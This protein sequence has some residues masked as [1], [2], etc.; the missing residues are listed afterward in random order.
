MLSIKDV[1]AFG[2]D[3]R[4]Y[5]LLTFEDSFSRFSGEQDV[6]TTGVIGTVSEAI[7]SLYWLDSATRSSL[8]PTNSFGHLNGGHGNGLITRRNYT[9]GSK[10]EVSDMGRGS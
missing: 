4:A 3:R 9:K 5:T 6:L 1:F 7:S 8:L 2:T 10:V